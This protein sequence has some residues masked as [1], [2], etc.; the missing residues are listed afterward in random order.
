MNQAGLS[1]YFKPNLASKMS[2]ANM[3][4]LK[5][6]ESHKLDEL[7]KGECFVQGTVFNFETKCPEDAIISGKTYLIP[8]SPLNK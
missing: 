6:S 8:N 5:K 4:G 1:V 7:N 3:L 2:V